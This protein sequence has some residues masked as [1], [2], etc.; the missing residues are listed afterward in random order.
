MKNFLKWVW[1]YSIPSN[2]P[3]LILVFTLGLVVGAFLYINGFHNGF[4]QC[5]SIYGP[6]E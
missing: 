6:H 3:L 1:N 4:T 5:Y 2:L